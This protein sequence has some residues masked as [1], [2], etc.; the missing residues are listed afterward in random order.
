MSHP[1]LN[2]SGIV[3]GVGQR[4]AA[5]V[6]QHVR[7]NREG[8]TGA[9]TEARD[10][11]VKALRR[12]R[13]ATLRAEHVRA[14]RLLALETTLSCGRLPRRNAMQKDSEDRIVFVRL[15]KTTRRLAF[16]ARH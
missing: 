9:L 11:C 13:A 12:D 2:G 7:V 14:G 15:R 10:Q 1:G 4:I 6:P 8:H 16:K 5:A 3:A